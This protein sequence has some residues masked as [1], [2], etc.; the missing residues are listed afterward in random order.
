[1]TARGRKEAGACLPGL[2]PKGPGPHASPR[3]PPPKLCR[4]EVTLVSEKARMGP[5]LAPPPQA[6]QALGGASPGT[7]AQAC[8][9]PP[10]AP[11]SQLTTLQASEEPP[12]LLCRKL[13]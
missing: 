1:M 7:G 2:W 3:V 12:G 8:R 5:D 9:R 10:A 11:S 6:C 4:F 13:H